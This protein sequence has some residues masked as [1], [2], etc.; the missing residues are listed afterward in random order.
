MTLEI[1]EIV[2]DNKDLACCGNCAYRSFRINNR[3]SGTVCEEACDNDRGS[4]SCGLCEDWKFDSL[5]MDERLC[6][7]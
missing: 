4:A 2:I 3:P 5:S 1:T 6:C 7:D